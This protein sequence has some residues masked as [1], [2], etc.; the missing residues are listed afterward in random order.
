MNAGVCQNGLDFTAKFAENAQ[1]A[2]IINLVKTKVFLAAISETVLANV[3]K[4]IKGLI[5]KIPLYVQLAQ[6]I[7]SARTTV[8]IKEFLENANANAQLDGQGQTARKLTIAIK[9][10]IIRFV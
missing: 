8:N 3:Q 5:V 10:R 9:D 2:Q 4:N 6:T 1:Q 7:W